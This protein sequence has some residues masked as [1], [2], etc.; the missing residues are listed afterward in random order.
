MHNIARSVP[1]EAV[2]EF[3][4]RL[5]E[6]LD[7]AIHDWRRVLDGTIQPGDQATKLVAMI[8]GIEIARDIAKQAK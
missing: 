4:D 3:Q 1:S 5:I 6:A 2:R 7:R 8:T